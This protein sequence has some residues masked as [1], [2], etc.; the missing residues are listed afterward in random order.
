M[1]LSSRAL[2]LTTGSNGSVAP[3]PRPMLVLLLSGV[4][5]LHPLLCTATLNPMIL[6]HAAHLPTD[7]SAYRT[8]ILH[9]ILYPCCYYVRC[10]YAVSDPF[11]GLLL[12]WRSRASPISAPRTRRQRRNPVSS[13]RPGLPTRHSRRPTSTRTP[14]SAISYLHCLNNVLKDILRLK[15]RPKVNIQAN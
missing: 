8:G 15:G 7:L 3:T 6:I 1:P 13:S 9:V 5:V 11:C 10:C 4:N 2:L 12:P 14:S